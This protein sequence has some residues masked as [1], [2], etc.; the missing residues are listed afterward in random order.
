ML[1]LR[2]DGVPTIDFAALLNYRVPLTDRSL[3]DSQRIIVMKIGS[4]SF[5]LLVDSVESIITYYAEDLLPLPMI[6]NSKASMFV[7]CI[8]KKNSQDII[9]LNPNYILSNSEVEAIT[10]GHSK[11]YQAN[12]AHESLQSKSKRAP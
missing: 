10:H 3:S 1:D 11:I 9:L 12:S 5:G 7:G 6:G 8:A 4:E 2:G